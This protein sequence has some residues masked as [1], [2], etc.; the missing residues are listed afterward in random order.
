MTLASTELLHSGGDKVVMRTT[1]TAA[2]ALQIETQTVVEYDGMGIVD[3]TLTP[4]QPIAIDGVDFRVNVVRQP[5]QQVLG[6]ATETVYWSGRDRFL[7]PCYSGSYKSIVGFVAR[8]F[9]FWWLADQ[10]DGWDR[11]TPLTTEI[12]CTPETLELNQPVVVG[13]RLLS[14]P[15]HYRFAFLATPVREL[16]PDFRS[17]RV[18]AGISANEARAGNVGLWWTDATAHFALPY[19][20]YPDGA[21]ERLSAAEIA[22]YPGAERNLANVQQWRNMGIDR[23]PYVSL[24]AI[25]PLDTEAQPHLADWRSLPE[26][27]TGGEVDDP[28]TTGFKRPLV[29]L[30]AEGFVDHQLE[31][32]SDIADR[33]GVRGFYFDQAEPIGSENPAHVAP[34]SDGSVNPVT[35]VLAMR[36]FFKQLAT[37]LYAKGRPPLL[38]VHNSTAPIIPAYTF[39]TA[40]VQ[41]EELNGV[42]SIRNFDYQ[43]SVPMSYVWPMYS[44]QNS[45]VPTVW[46][47]ELW[48]EVFAANRPAPYV[49]DTGGWLQSGPFGLAWR[50]FMAM[51]LLNDIPVWTLAPVAQREALYAQ[52]DRF[53]VNVSD[54]HGYWEFGTSWPGQPVL[55]SAYVRPEGP[56][57][58]LVA[59][60][61][62]TD[63]Q[64]LSASTVASWFDAADL[65]VATRDVLARY[66]ASG[67]Q[68]AIAPR[69]FTLIEIR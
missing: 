37:L 48:S 15:V 6:F 22:A 28:Y 12:R 49:S 16:T 40:M 56:A 39:V 51:A 20:D 58:L 36:D 54:F 50:N 65:P 11:G 41:G 68:V 59:A 10:S 32:L 31:R 2:G 14:A 63:E 26:I 29:S 62:T 55:V 23:L 17:N 53:G 47:E 69:D 60:N 61:A 13:H 35:D 43:G 67:A 42:S 52:M 27:A 25:S 24:R 3:V 30:R 7:E 21:R 18:V 1:A 44:P 66:G 9:S 38:Y 33:L 34:G 19:L 45:G 8:Q 64:T 57:I 4:T 5:E 46:L